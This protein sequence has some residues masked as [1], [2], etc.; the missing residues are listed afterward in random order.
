MIPG[1]TIF[2]KI[3]IHLVSELTYQGTRN[4]YTYLHEHTIYHEQN[5]LPDSF[6]AIS[7]HNI[8]KEKC[9]FEFK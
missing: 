2:F 8:S 7:C 3:F 4:D 9:Q 1:L 6:T 5:Y